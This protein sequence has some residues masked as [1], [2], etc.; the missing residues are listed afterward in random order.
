M[1]HPVKLLNLKKYK[2]N[3]FGKMEILNWNILLLKYEKGGLK[4]V[5]I[6][7]KITSLQCSQVKRLYDD[8][9]P[10]WKV[11][12]LFFL[13]DYLGKNFLL[14]IYKN[15][16]Y[17]RYFLKKPTWIISLLFLKIMVR[18]KVRKIWEQN[19]IWMTIRNFIG[20]KLSPQSLLLKKKFVQN[21]VTIS[22]ILLL[23]NM[24]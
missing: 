19:W 7:P 18:W 2:N 9:F 6:F 10:A 15:P 24:T 4:I 21:V 12:P 22:V 5:G 14:K 8:S 17:Y 23:T 1:Y 20:D 16:I 11:I 13:K 3:L